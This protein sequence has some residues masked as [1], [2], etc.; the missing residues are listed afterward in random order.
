MYVKEEVEVGAEGA[1]QAE[2]E[3]GN[4]EI[5]KKRENKRRRNRQM[6]RKRGGGRGLTGSRNEKH[7]LRLSISG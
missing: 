1:E 3:A 2:A 6:K 5:K 4:K 7:H